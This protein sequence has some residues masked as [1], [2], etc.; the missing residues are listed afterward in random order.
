MEVS[1]RYAEQ[2]QTTVETM[3]RRGLAIY[4]FFLKLGRRGLGAA[5]RAWE[6]AEPLAYD[7][8]DYVVQA[9]TDPE[10]IDLDDKET[11]HNL[12]EL[13]LALCVLMVGVGAGELMGSMVL[14][15]VLNSMLDV[16][17]QVAL[18]L[19]VPVYIYLTFRKNAALDDTERRVWLFGTCLIEGSLIGNLM[20][21]KAISTV[22]GSFFVVPLALGLLADSEFSPSYVY[23]DRNRLIG[24]SCAFAG[25]ASLILG[26]IPIGYTS[27]TIIV[28]SLLHSGLLFVHFQLVIASFKSK[29][30]GNTEALFGYVI[31]LLI[32]Q[33]IVA[34]LFGG[35]AGTVQEAEL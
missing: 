20:G 3:R 34:G 22:P 8:R 29:N 33:I 35:A 6:M 5:E 10:P 14:G 2:F 24:F 31:L 17:V 7:C 30:F 23:A 9:C 19:V 28:M 18:L 21:E 32:L 27:F 25:V 4:D 13:Y 1:Q 26:S 16:W 12:L 15:S 11:R